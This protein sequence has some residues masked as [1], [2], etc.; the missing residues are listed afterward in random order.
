MLPVKGRW[1]TAVAEFLA[2]GLELL[3]LG[4]WSRSADAMKRFCPLVSQHN[5]IVRCYVEIST[6]SIAAHM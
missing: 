5:E 3:L 4:A 6:R 2:A 1:H